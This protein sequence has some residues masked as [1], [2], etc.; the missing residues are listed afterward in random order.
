MLLG[1]PNFSN[2]SR[3]LGYAASDDAVENASSVQAVARGLEVGFPRDL[4]DT[5][6]R[7]AQNLVLRVEMI[8]LNGKRF[9]WPRS[10][11]DKRRGFGG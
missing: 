1:A 7:H 5:H 4:A 3:V 2:P 6:A 10:T 9:D 11:G 8:A